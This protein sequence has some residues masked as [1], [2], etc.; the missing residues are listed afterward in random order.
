MDRFVRVR[1]SL[2]YLKMIMRTFDGYSVDNLMALDSDKQEYKKRGIAF[3][4]MCMALLESMGCRCDSTPNSDDD[5]IDIICYVQNRVINIQCKNYSGSVGK[6][7]VQEVISG[8]FA[9]PCHMAAVFTNSSFT[10]SAQ[11][12]AEKINRTPGDAHVVLVDG[13][14]LRHFSMRLFGLADTVEFL[15]VSAANV[16]D[17]VPL[18]T[19]AQM[20]TG[21]EVNDDH[22]V[23]FSVTPDIVL[24]LIQEK[25]LQ[26]SNN[27][28]EPYITKAS[29]VA[30][31]KRLFQMMSRT[32]QSL[33]ANLGYKLNTN[34]F[35]FFL[36]EYS[37]IH[38]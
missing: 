36:R 37:L 16:K 3:E 11:E 26:K 22:M 38:L 8:S 1:P 32:S 34:T 30:Y 13:Y 15:T 25:K 31:N 28:L 6:E 20:I 12:F 33:E 2:D 35:Y 24:K 19:A 14:D 27:I 18:G 7:A 9:H 17:S 5:G 23:S 10:T 29:I 4:K 21:Y